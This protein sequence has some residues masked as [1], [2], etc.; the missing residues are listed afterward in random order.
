MMSRPSDLHGEALSPALEVRPLLGSE[1]PDLPR[2]TQTEELAVTR[3]DRP[4]TARP[5]PTGQSLDGVVR[6]LMEKIGNL[7]DRLA[8]LVEDN[9]DVVDRVA[10]LETRANTK[11]SGGRAL[12]DDAIEALR[13]LEKYWPM[14]FTAYSLGSNLETDDHRRLGGQLRVLLTR[15]LVEIHTEPNKTA[16]WSAVDPAKRPERPT[17]A[18][19]GE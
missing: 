15:G 12:N 7:E 16:L 17:K 10:L 4:N 19:L 14:K 5:A 3:S 18:G 6:M 13:Y 11:G 2:R 9:A 1:G 8:V